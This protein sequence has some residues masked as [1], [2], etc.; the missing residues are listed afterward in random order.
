MKKCN[1]DCFNCIYDDCIEDE[2]NFTIEESFLTEEDKRYSKRREYNRAY[3]LANKEK[4]KVYEERK[5]S[6][7][8]GSENNEC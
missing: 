7:K 6:K 1:R 8:A 5:K 2:C 3:Y 4:W